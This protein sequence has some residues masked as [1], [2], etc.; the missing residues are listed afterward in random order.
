[1]KQITQRKFFIIY[2]ILLLVAIEIFMILTINLTVAS[3]SIVTALITLFLSPLLGSLIVMTTV[4]KYIGKFTEDNFNKVFRIISILIYMLGYLIV[5]TPNMVLLSAYIIGAVIGY[6][7][8]KKIIEKMKEKYIEKESFFENT[9]K[10][11]PYEFEKLKSENIQE[12]LK[13][14]KITGVEFLIAKIQPIKKKYV[15]WKKSIKLPTYIICFD[16]QYMY[17]FELTKKTKEY[18]EKGYV[19]EMDKFMV[20]RTKE[21]SSKYILEL[22]FE[23]GNIF[24]VYIPKTYRRLE[25]QKENSKKL[26]EKLININKEKEKK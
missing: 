11:K 26:Y 14:N 1:M 9:K 20:N 12:F 2:A 13:I 4:K 23:E 7:S 16:N 21:K 3:K 10:I 5:L 6:L 22:E 19:L 15:L 24:N 25:I 8:N 17:F 18:T